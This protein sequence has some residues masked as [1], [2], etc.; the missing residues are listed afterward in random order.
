MRLTPESLDVIDLADTVLHA[1]HDISPIW[2]YLRSAPGIY[3]H[4]A[5]GG[6]AP[7]WVVSRHA[8]V[9]EVLR[10]GQTFSSARGNVLDTLLFGGDSAAGQMLVVSD[11]PRHTEISRV[12]RP[13]FSPP[14]LEELMRAVRVEARCLIRTAVERGE[15][16]FARDVSAL[17]PLTAICKMMGIPESDRVHLSRLTADSLSSEDGAMTDIDTFSAKNEI[18]VYFA[19]L[20]IFRREHPGPRYDIVTLLAQS[21]PA[22][23][24]IPMPEV[25]FNCFNLLVA[26]VETSRL[27]MNG[28]VMTF[29]DRPDQWNRVKTSAVDLTVAVEEILR[30]TTPVLHAARQVTRPTTLAGQRIEAGEIVSVWL[31]SANVDD[32]IFDRPNEFDLAR[33]PNRHLAFSFGPHFCLGAPLARLE[34][35]A[36]LD[37][38]AS[39]VSDLEITGQPTRLYSNFLQGFCE[40]P[41]RLHPNHRATKGVEYE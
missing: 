26:G 33:R 28:A 24:P 15:C 22:G 38:L 39:Q 14:A 30:W 18:L 10:D 31:T 25:I 8:D 21:E 20:A 17:I 19:E 4:R 32:E 16:D 29:A 36:V 35:A 1:E 5:I 41:T 23:L 40:L 7:F 9:V 12:V 3:R 37:E 2:A 27:S 11:A 6:R 13:A 34:I